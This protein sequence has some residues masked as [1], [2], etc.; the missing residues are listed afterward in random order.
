MDDAVLVAAPVLGGI[1]AKSS[2]TT[3]EPALT[4]TGAEHKCLIE[5]FFC[6][7]S[8]GEDP[9]RSSF[10]IRAHGTGD[11]GDVGVGRS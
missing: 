1:A 11:R 4:Q 7:D 6:F 8:F 2:E 10:G 5:V 3:E 9:R